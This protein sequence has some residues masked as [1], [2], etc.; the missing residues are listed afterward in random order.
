MQTREQRIKQIFK[1]CYE[2]VSKYS[3]GIKDGDW[4]D[5]WDYHKGK[6]DDNDMLAVEMY[7]ACINELE[8]QYRA[9][10]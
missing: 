1:T 2:L 5:I 6:L 7:T 8:R 3:N 10:E 9:G 4:L